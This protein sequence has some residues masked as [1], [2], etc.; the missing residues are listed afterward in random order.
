MAPGGGGKRKRGDRSFSGDSRDENSRP[1][2]YKPGELRLGQQHSLQQSPQAQSF[3][4][5]GYD[6]QRGGGR[7]RA[8]RGGRGGGSQRSPLNSPNAIPVQPRPNSSSSKPMSPPFSHSQPITETKD[9]P[10]PQPSLAPGEGTAQVL[11]QQPEN[12]A[13]YYYEHITEEKLAAWGESGRS[14]VV[15]DGEKAREIK[16][17]RVLGMLFQEVIR[18][19]T[20]A[21][22]E[23]TDAGLMIKEI[24]GNTE[25]AKT[26]QVDIVDH[27]TFDATSLFLDNLSI[28]TET[29]KA[30]PALVTLVLATGISPSKMRRELD[31]ALL[32]SLGLIRNTFVRVG[33]RQQTNL[34]YRQSNYNLLREET[35]GYSK[36]VTEFFT[37]SNNEPP[38]SEIVEETFERVKGMIGAFD[39]DVGRVLDITLDVFAAVLVK[40]YRFFVKYLRASSWWPPN[41]STKITPTQQL[42]GPLPKWAFPGASNRGLND[43]EKVEMLRARTERDE[44]FWQRCKELGLAAFFELGGRQTEDSTLKMA[45]AGSAASS[46]ANQYEEDRKWIEVTR[47]LP[48]PGNKVA[49]QV[50]GFKLRF[51]SSSARDPADVLPIN[52]IFLA[53]LLIKVGFISADSAMEQLRDEKMKEKS[54]REKLNRPGGGTANA[55]L[56]AAPLPDDT[57]EGQ[58][59]ESTRLREADAA[60]R[61]ATK[62]D[63]ATGGST[64][65]PQVEDKTDELPEPAEQKVQL[66]KSLLCIGA[67]PEALYMLGRFPWLPDAFP[68]LPEYIHRILHHCLSK[69]YEPLRPLSEEAGLR[70]Q[71][72]LPDPDAPK[73]SLK[74]VDAPVRRTLRWAQ[75]DKDD[76]S[77]ATD[78][79]FYWDDW[80][81]ALPVCQ[82]VDDVFT[83]CSTLLNYSGVRIGQDAT[84]LLKLSRI[85][86]HSLATDASDTNTARWI[87]LSK[88]L[89][90]PALSLTKCNPGV[91]NEVFDLIKNF[92]TRT[93]YNIYAEWYSGQTS[94]LSD[95]KSAFDQTRAETKDVL[96][97]IAK[98]NI[99][100]MARALAKVAY[101]SPGVVFSVAIAQL[102]A[103]RNLT[104]VVVECARYFTY[105]AYDVLTWSLMSALG[106]QGRNRVQSD[107]MLTSPWLAAL[108]AFAG[109]VFKRYSVMNPT[110]IIQYVAEQLRQGNSTDL[111]VL[112]A[113]TESMG[114]IVPNYNF[115]ESQILG[116]AGGEILQGQT[117]LKLRDHRHECKTTAR[118]LMRSLTDSNLAGQVLVSLAQERQT[119]IFRIEE[120]NAHPK[121]LGEVFDRLHNSFIQYLDLLRSNLSVGI[122][123]TTVPNLKRLLTEFGIEPTIAFS[124]CRP[125]IKAAMAE[126]DTRHRRRKFDANKNTT[127]DIVAS[128][129]PISNGASQ[130]GQS[131]IQADEV[132]GSDQSDPL[133]SSGPQIGEAET[134][135]AGVRPASDDA[136]TCKRD[137]QQSNA[138]SVPGSIHPIR[139]ELVDLVRPIL[140]EDTWKNLSPS[141][142]A[143]FWQMSLGDIFISVV[144]YSEEATRLSEKNKELNQKAKTD[145]GPI[146]AQRRDKELRSNTELHSRMS[147]ESSDRFSEY[148]QD[149]TRLQ[150]ESKHWFSDF[151]G[152]RDALNVALIE[153]CFFPRLIMSPS[154]A[155][156]AFKMLKTLHGLGTPNFHTMSFYDHFFVEKRLT[157]M[158]F[159]CSSQEAQSFGRYLNDVLQELGQWHASKTVF[160]REAHGKG[161]DLPGFARKIGI[162]KNTFYEYEDFRRILHKWHR[163]LSI[164]LKICLGG[165]EY[166]HIHNAMII[167]RN[168]VP[169]FPVVNWMGK[170]ALASIEELS[171]L[172]TREDLKTSAMSLIGPLRK[173]EKEWIMPQAFHLVG[174]KPL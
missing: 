108:A 81:D 122:F 60:R 121:L 33:I 56:A 164:A 28:L 168:V 58:A 34:L 23:A 158:I 5:D 53:A 148:R 3:G 70:E 142:Y 131:A 79:R 59:R 69:V 12:S 4:R 92:P 63:T 57:I 139:Q 107:G 117:L 101:S 77:E 136:E 61:A 112:R 91:V 47:T 36:L 115:N 46:E 145:P 78:Y 40:Q 71:Q 7:R 153:H 74:F 97:R 127:K 13:P 137:P 118:R 83:L 66:L 89:L 150:E 42:L 49:A 146:A 68:D 43:E 17:P 138:S 155:M 144:A 45:I 95:I 162:E 171:M 135:T 163:N 55:L 75:L 50:L 65:N 31:S 126:Y 119:C 51:Y 11:E 106:G 76:T 90:V 88:R 64:P 93:R 156:Y 30:T 114:G 159:L 152:R 6:Y 10:A 130:P 22:I 123:D 113:I 167:L 14:E 132:A 98:T 129:R 82:N 105:L 141:F 48:P 27:P 39:L 41:T 73:G 25:E 16:D 20:D 151:K 21:R 111:D 18:A 67:L 134:D 85:G 32:E 172:E 1:S 154:D 169:N 9:S 94:R 35:E 2:P 86:S 125:S 110:P 102:E 160:E 29:T 170:G 157:S 161:K 8:S 109:M 149:R 124:I 120:R 104:E 96:K 54:E 24:L 26:S 72:K 174:S 62:I 103:Y 133:I 44:A 173:R 140:P 80:A 166:M 38:S 99:K 19:G 100:P 84:L 165:G 147:E 37:T 143:T 52:L 87:D 116:M 128:D 15:A